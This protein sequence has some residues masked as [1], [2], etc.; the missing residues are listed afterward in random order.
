MKIL[1]R[2]AS[3]F[4]MHYCAFVNRSTSGVAFF[5]IGCVLCLSME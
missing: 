3:H 4:A 5:V 1:S 2:F